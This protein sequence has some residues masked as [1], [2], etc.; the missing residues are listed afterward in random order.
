MSLGVQ[1]IWDIVKIQLKTE[2][3]TCNIITNTMNNGS[4]IENLYALVAYSNSVIRFPQINSRII[5]LSK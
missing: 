4:R 3:F 2:N 5:T 1:N